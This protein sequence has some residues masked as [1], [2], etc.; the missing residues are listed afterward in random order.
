MD[1]KITLTEEA[2][3]QAV[4][5]AWTETLPRVSYGPTIE[6]ADAGADSLDTLHLILRLET[7]LGRKVPFDLITPDMTPRSLTRQLLDEPAPHDDG[8]KPHNSEKPPIFLI[9]GVFG[10]EPIFADFRRSLSSHGR[11]Q[12]LELPDLD[13]PASL[14]SD[15][16]A[17]GRFAATEIARR[18]PQGNILLAGYS[19]GGCVALEATAFLLAQGRQVVFLGLLDP[20]APFSVDDNRVQEPKRQATSWRQYQLRWRP[21]FKKLLPHFE[22]DMF[23]YIDR[24]VLAVLVQLKAFDRGRRWILSAR[25]RVSLEG[26]VRRRNYLLGQLRLTALKRWRPSSLDVPTLLVMCEKSHTSGSSHLWPRFCSNLNILR[27]PVRHR[28]IFEPQA[29]DRLAPAFV[30]AVK[31]AGLAVSAPAAALDEFR[32]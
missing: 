3:D 7:Y 18:L 5:R 27:L 15:M 2:L 25:H 20:V 29:L 9:P 6:W 4:K 23:G 1:G 30:E 10:D 13:C 8:A 12:T 32:P 28:E 24:L 22:E 21:I 19:F 31:A 17:T 26:F 16:V 14:L 11:L